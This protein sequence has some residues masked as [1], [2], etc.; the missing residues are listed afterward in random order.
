VSEE[1]VMRLA[2]IT[3]EFSQD[4][5][6]VLQ[7]VKETTIISGLELRSIFG[8]ALHELDNSVIKEIGA[9][10]RK[11]GFLIPCIA[12][13]LF[14]CSI[15]SSK[16]VMEHFLLLERYIEVASLIHVPLLRCF[17][18]WREGNFNENL[19]KIADILGK[20]ADIC[21]ERK[22]T[23][24]LENEADT[25]AGTPE[26]IRALFLSLNKEN[27]FLLW[28]PANVINTWLFDEHNK[29][30]PYPD[31]YYLVKQ[32]IKHVHIKNQIFDI[33]KKIVKPSTL[34]DGNFDWKGQIVSLLNDGYR[35]F[36]SL[37]THYRLNKLLENSLLREPK[38]YAFSEGG[39]E[40]TKI[41]V[42][43]MRE[44]VRDYLVKIL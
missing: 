19:P 28:D 11:E 18:F 2:L 29:V 44:F 26:E 14:K 25:F 43:E 24:V 39:E 36:F 16:E 42:D 34:N 33:E 35:G 20:A 4:L 27:L 37:E 9:V 30:S 12:S 38:G 41:C 8:K 10:I 5:N 40:A 17:S 3:D 23:L 13:P 21:K 32:Y 15:H 7:F 31:G 6:R 1:I 22:I